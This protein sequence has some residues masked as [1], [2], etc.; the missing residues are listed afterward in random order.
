MRQP[1]NVQTAI[2]AAASPG[3]IASSTEWAAH[4][5][6]QDDPSVVVVA[7]AGVVVTGDA[8]AAA[9]MVVVVAAD[10]AR[11]TLALA[12]EDSTAG[13]KTG[14]AEEDD[15]A[16][17]LRNSYRPLKRPFGMMMMIAGN[18]AGC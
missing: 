11:R 1:L 18:C 2:V 3:W 9:A 5:A 8:A 16:A 4:P 13:A 15:P 7:A 6:V 14:T 10:F 17:A 12:L